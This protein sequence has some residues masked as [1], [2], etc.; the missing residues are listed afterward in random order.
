MHYIHYL[1]DIIANVAIILA[2][3]FAFFSLR[4]M[5]KAREADHERRKKQ[6]TID[7]IT[8][9]KKT[10]SQIEWEIEKR[11]VNE[12]LPLD[13]ISSDEKFEHGIIT[14]LSLMEYLSVSVKLNVYDKEIL[15]I[16]MGTRVSRYYDWLHPYIQKRRNQIKNKFL[17]CEFQRLANEMTEKYNPYKT[18]G[19]DV[20]I[21]Q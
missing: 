10:A 13:A 9:L 3:F 1:V 16:L 20:I 18:I 8:E 14:Y 7:Y 5:K 12:V 2:T 4:E 21:K 17:C 11:I 15:D 6:S 19:D